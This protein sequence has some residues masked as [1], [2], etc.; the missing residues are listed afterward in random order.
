M[1]ARAE[2]LVRVMD[3]PDMY[4]EDNDGDPFL[5]APPRR[6]ERSGRTPFVQRVK[7]L[8][9]GVRTTPTREEKARLRGED[10]ARPGRTVPQSTITAPTSLLLEALCAQLA[11]AG[12]HVD[13]TEVAELCSLLRLQ[14]RHELN[15]SSY[16]LVD[17][18]DSLACELGGG[19]AREQLGSGSAAHD[20]LSDR[21][22]DGLCHL[23]MRA[24]YRLFS[25]RE[26]RF[27]AS[28]S[29]MFRMPVTVGWESL[30]SAMISRLFVRHPHLGLQVRARA[31][32]K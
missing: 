32:M 16:W 23:F 20:D 14:L 8:L 9:T 1:R 11:A 4:E 5:D 18:F 10:S 31:R 24:N 21:F 3:D 13:E 19:G 28:E 27:S 15:E 22:I 7:N 2:S 30:D 26:W 6:I 25:H 12:E 17:A 29:F